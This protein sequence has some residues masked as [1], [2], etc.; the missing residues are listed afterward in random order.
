MLRRD[1]LRRTSI[2]L[3]GGLLLGDAALE[4]FE[5]LT[6]VRKS[7]PSAAI[8]KWTGRPVYFDIPYQAGAAMI[9]DGGYESLTITPALSRW[10]G[11]G[12]VDWK[13]LGLDPKWEEFCLTV[14]QKTGYVG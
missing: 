9:P 6:H 13:G 1:F 12:S 11:P 8:Q 14:G 2:A 4:A 5:R 10:I 7:F 3:A